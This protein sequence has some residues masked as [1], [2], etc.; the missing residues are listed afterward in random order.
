MPNKKIKLVIFDLSNV[1]FS[2]EEPPF[3][4]DFCLEYNLDEQK[5]DA[6][7]QTLLKKAE[8]DEMSGTEVWERMLKAY[9]ISGNPKKII[10]KMM[11]KKYEHQAV[12]DLVRKIKDLGLPV[13]Y[14]T[15]YNK[16]YWELIAKRWDMNNYFSS[17]LVSYQIKVRKPAREGFIK[18][19]DTYKVKPDETLFIDDMKQNLEKA[20][21]CGIGGHLFSSV[22]ELKEFLKKKKL[23]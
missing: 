7:Y 21:E 3:I 5:F 2:M 10:K 13:V 17:G 23:L 1:C 6:E 12:L 9:K 14:L 18:L 4:H 16:D 19:M 22:S 15:N 20:K 8:V 11:D